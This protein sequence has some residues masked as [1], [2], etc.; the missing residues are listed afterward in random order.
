MLKRAYA[1]GSFI[2]ALRLLSGMALA[3]AALTVSMSA[4]LAA[5]AFEASPAAQPAPAAPKAQEESS[6]IEARPGE[7]LERTGSAV[8]V[9][10]SAIVSNKHVLEG[11]SR[12]VA[13]NDGKIAE[14]ENIILSPDTDLAAALFPPDTFSAYS[15]IADRAPDKGDKLYAIGYPEGISRGYHSKY[16]E[17]VFS[18]EIDDNHFMHTAQIYSGSSGSGL[19]NWH[20]SMVG[21]NTAADTEM[22]GM[23]YALSIDAIKIFLT[24]EKIAFADAWRGYGVKSNE[25]SS[26]AVFC[27]VPDSP[28]AA[29]KKDAAAKDEKEEESGDVDFWCE[30]RVAKVGEHGEWK[31]FR[32]GKTF[33]RRYHFTKNDLIITSLTSG[34]SYSY[35]IDKSQSYKEGED[36]EGVLLVTHSDEGAKQF[37][38][39]LN[40]KNGDMELTEIL[41]E[42][43]D[44]T[45]RLSGPCG[46][47]F[48]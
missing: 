6:L 39:L 1:A 43:D 31:P 33:R 10:K 34:N 12:V 27:F 19:Y 17:G 42:K 9:N 20:G 28:P 36:S 25:K 3:L 24:E 40:R 23:N 7:V 47:E 16:T 8:A 48:K 15:I 18:S 38:F 29:D 11:C 14:A 32:E 13:A 37:D 41:T 35:R 22:P 2:I 21:V 46:E 4:A 44:G 30:L 45:I 26:F 5:E